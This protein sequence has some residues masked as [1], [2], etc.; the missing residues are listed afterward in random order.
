MLPSPL[1]ILKKSLICRRC[2]GFHRKKGT[3]ILRRA[4]VAWGRHCPGQKKKAIDLKKVTFLII[5]SVKSSK[6]KQCLITNNKVLNLGCGLCKNVSR[7][8]LFTIMP[9]LQ[10][11]ICFASKQHSHSI[12]FDLNTNPPAYGFIINLSINYTLYVSSKN[13]KK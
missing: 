6:I 9:V 10:S 7:S 12:E 11:F 13:S 8:L 5:Y 4:K 2:C 1:I 3:M